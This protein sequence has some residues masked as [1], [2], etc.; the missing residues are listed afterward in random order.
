MEPAVKLPHLPLRAKELKRLQG[1]TRPLDAW[2]RYR[3]LNDAI[4]EAYDLIDIGNREARFALIL[5]SALNAVVVVAASRPEVTTAL[6]QRQRLWAGVAMGVYALAAVHFMLQAIE[7]LRP[8][9]FSPKFGNWSPDR[10]DYPKKVRYFEDVVQR[11][12]ESHWQAWREVQVG[13]LNAELAVQ[14][15]GL[16]VKNQVKRVGLRRLYAG[17]QIMTLMV[18]ALLAL[19]FYAVWVAPQ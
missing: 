4:D 5:M 13:Q 14:L 17:L 10:A 3:A 15:H 2:E 8:G 11:D 7:A 18:V 9:R 19:F 16:C 1:D 12:L 6:G